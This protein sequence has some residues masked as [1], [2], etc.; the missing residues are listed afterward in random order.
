MQMSDLK[1][2]SISLGELNYL[3]NLTLQGNLIDDEMCTWLVSGLICNHT[4]RSLDLS[5]NRISNKG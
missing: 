3:L 1:T 4:L 2:F 5:N